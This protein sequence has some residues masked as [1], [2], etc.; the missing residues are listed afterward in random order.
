MPSCINDDAIFSGPRPYEEFY[1]SVIAEARE[2]ALRKRAE[3]GTGNISSQGV[4][5]VLDRVLLDK[6]ARIRRLSAIVKADEAVRWLSSE[7]AAGLLVEA[8]GDLPAVWHGIS[9]AREHMEKDPGVRD[10]ILDVINYLVIALALLDGSW[11]SA[12]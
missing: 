10:D 6:L 8:S 3:Y 4:S 9:L 12:G 7:D 11:E 5:G 2:I 1:D